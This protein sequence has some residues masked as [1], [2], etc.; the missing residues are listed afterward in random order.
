MT[1]TNPLEHSNRPAVSALV[2]HLVIDRGRR[3]R[4]GKRRKRGKKKDDTEKRECQAEI[5]ETER[6]YSAVTFCDIV[7]RSLTSVENRGV[8][9]E[10]QLLA[11]TETWL[12]DRVHNHELTVMGTYP[13][14]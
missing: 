12:D 8:A 3:G 6:R 9:G 5:E 11:F 10:C 4:E 2:A 7:K 1:R 14:G 13:S